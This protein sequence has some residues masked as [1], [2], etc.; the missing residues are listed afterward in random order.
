MIFFD[1]DKKERI[2]RFA[3]QVE[4]EIQ[5]LEAGEEAG[6]RGAYCAFAMKDAKLKRHAGE[7]IR[8]QL[9]CMDRFRLWKLCERFRTFTSL[10]WSI[11]WKQASVRRMQK[12]LPPEV[13]WYVLILGSF[14]PNGYFREQCVYAM[15]DHAD[16]QFW[17]FPRVN[18]WVREVRGA[19][20]QVLLQ[21]LSVCSGTEL[22]SVL[23][24][25]ERLQGCR[26]RTESQMKAI[27]EQMEKRLSQVMGEMDL[28]ELFSLEPEV[29]KALYRLNGRLKCFTL[30]ELHFCL[31]RERQ[32]DLKRMLIKKILEHPDCTLDWAEAYLSDSS[33]QVR[34]A[35]VEFRYER[36]KDAWPG[37]EEMLLDDSRGVREY[38]AYILERRRGFD[39][40]GF[41]LDH[42]GDEKPASAILGLSEC[43]DS[44]NVQAL[45]D[46][47]ERKER[48]ILKCTLLAL[49]T[50]VDFADEELLWCYLLDDRVEVSKAAYLSIRKKGFRPGANRLYEAYQKAGMEHQRRYLLRLLLREGAWSRLPCLLR[51][52][53]RDLP[54]QEQYQVLSGI[55]TRSMYGKLPQSMKEEIRSAL[56][57][58]RAELPKWVEPGILYDMK[59]L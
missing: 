52:Y 43:S 46:C 51:L 10:E 4:L 36:T 18:D 29:R 42:L 30:P 21:S 47:L 35:A 11:D 37:L 32:A 12:E 31:G 54:L 41:Y 19:A 22:L 6:I 49:G 23:P 44:G 50:Q 13:Y 33:A 1:E 48:R 26:R 3:A 27:E 8:K 17:L 56:E 20:C 15:K 7:A 16:L 55:R 39:L 57:E 59:F 40:R 14:H 34:K 5:R 2:R 38:A 25:Y 24:A 9:S 53:R 28:E 58:N 45:L